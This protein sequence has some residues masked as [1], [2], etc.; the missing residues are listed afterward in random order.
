MNLS[1]HP[2]LGQFVFLSAS[3]TYPFFLL[4]LRPKTGFWKGGLQLLFIISVTL[5]AG[6]VGY[7]LWYSY[8]EYKRLGNEFHLFEALDWTFGESLAFYLYL[9]VMPAAIP[10]AIWY[11][12]GYLV[13]FQLFRLVGSYS[14]REELSNTKTIK[15]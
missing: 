1:G 5:I 13:S 4:W 10:A 7:L 8:L 14:E 6:L 11:P 12:I 2:N 15:E 9:D 3:L